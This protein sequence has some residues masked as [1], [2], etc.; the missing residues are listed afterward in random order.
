MLAIFENQNQP[1]YYGGNWS[2]LIEGIELEQYKQLHHTIKKKQVILQGMLCI[3]YVFQTK[4]N[5]IIPPQLHTL[6]S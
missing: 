4:T 1:E 5:N 3:Q 2:I 6:K